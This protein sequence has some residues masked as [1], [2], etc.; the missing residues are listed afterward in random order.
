M[1]SW[2]SWPTIFSERMKFTQILQWL[3][4]IYFWRWNGNFQINDMEIV[5]MWLSVENLEMANS[6]KQ[7]LAPQLVAMQEEAS[8]FICGFWESHLPIST[9]ASMN[10]YG[11]EHL[12]KSTSQCFRATRHQC[13]S[14][15]L[16]DCQWLK[17]LPS[18]NL[19]GRGGTLSLDNGPDGR[20]T[21]IP[22]QHQHWI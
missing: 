15:V 6:F 5:T 9:L 7:R 8:Q 10:W 3:N 4:T 17:I 18:G 11:K 1:L 16:A 14:L 21:A 12:W 22:V 20:Y 19:V 2:L 13:L